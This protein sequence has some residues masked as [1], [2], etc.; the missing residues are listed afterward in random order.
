MVNPILKQ[1]LIE[2]LQPKLGSEGLEIVIDKLFDTGILDERKCKIA[3]IRKYINDKIIS[4]MRDGKRPDTML[5]IEDAAVLFSVPASFVQN[6]L[7]KF[8][9]INL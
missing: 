2:I 8:K 7:Y 4:N 3:V 6:S 5:L 1:H 9:N